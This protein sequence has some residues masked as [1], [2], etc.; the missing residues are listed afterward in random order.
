MPNPGRCH[1]DPLPPRTCQIDPAEFEMEVDDSDNLDASGCCQ[2]LPAGGLIET[3][4]SAIFGQMGDPDGDALNCTDPAAFPYTA[5][6]F[7]CVDTITVT[8]T[9]SDSGTCVAISTATIIEQEEE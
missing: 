5:P 4:A 2:A 1:P 9:W 6:S 8:F 7:P 3:Q